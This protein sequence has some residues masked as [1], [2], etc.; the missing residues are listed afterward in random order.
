[1]HNSVS[2]DK[3][4]ITGGAGFIGSHLVDRLMEAGH[5]VVVVDNL[6]NSKWEHVA[7]WMRNPRFTFIEA[8]LRHQQVVRQVAGLAKDASLVFHL[9]A[10]PDVR[11][12]LTGPAAYIDNNILVT[13]QLLEALKEAD[14][15]RTIGFVSSSTVYGDA[16]QVPTPEDYAHMRPISLY[17][18][19][20]LA[21]EALLSAYAFSFGFRV[22]LFRPANVIGPRATHGVIRDFIKK[23]RQD[24]TRLEIYGN[25]RQRKSYVYVDDCVDAFLERAA[26]FL[27]TQERFQVYNVGSEDQI[28]VRRIAQVVCEEMSV[29]GVQFVFTGGVDGGRGWIGDVKD[30]QLSI[31]RLLATGWRPRYNSE[32]TARQTTRLLIGQAEGAS[33]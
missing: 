17:G 3:V 9:A 30:M 5:Q 2:T 20:K 4:V 6:S 27:G 15:C 31:D 8:D 29:Q 32:S 19:S 18:A 22:L 26:W 11:I 21:C 14:A 33:S 16:T 25:G 10:E 28:E 1:M 24:P 12:P 7:Q 13:Y 23:L